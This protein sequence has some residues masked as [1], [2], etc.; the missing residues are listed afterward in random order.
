VKSTTHFADLNELACG[1]FLNK[2]VWWN[3]HAEHQFLHKAHL[4]KT[5]E[6][7]AHVTIQVERGRVM[8]EC[9]RAHWLMH[10]GTPLCFTDLTWCARN[11]QSVLPAATPN[12]PADLLIKIKESWL[13]I[14]CKSRSE[15]QETSGWKNIGLGTIEASLGLT[16]NGIVQEALDQ[17]GQEHPELRNVS[18]RRRK[19]IIRDSERIQRTTLA[20]ATTCL[21]RVRD[22]TLAALH[23]V[24]QDTVKHFLR[25]TLLDCD[26]AVYPKY[27]RLIGTGSTRHAFKARLHD[28]YRLPFAG[29][30]IPLALGNQAIGFKSDQYRICLMRAKFE[31]E[32]LASS[33]K[34]SVDPWAN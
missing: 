6:G 11:V 32:P 18:A 33:L 25:S 9:F 15:T 22:A 16:L 17:I 12:H 20:C 2:E 29:T 10:T 8:A 5:T 24:P 14:S 7:A 3:K 26:D 30:L 19:S 31:S 13:G 28:P 4:I 27:I 21:T 34:F 23:T 1:Y